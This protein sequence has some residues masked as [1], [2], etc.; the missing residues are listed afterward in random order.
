[1]ELKK[2][3]E[4]QVLLVVEDGVVEEVGE[5]RHLPLQVA[6]PSLGGPR[7]HF[8]PKYS[9]NFRM[10]VALGRFSLHLKF[11]GFLVMGHSSRDWT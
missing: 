6:R 10:E 8:H 2:M 1:M 3:D 5:G 9:N 11:C 7:Q 4:E